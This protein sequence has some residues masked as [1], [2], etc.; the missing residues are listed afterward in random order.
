MSTPRN[1]LTDQEI[2]DILSLKSNHKAPEIA[3]RIGRG[4]SVVRRVLSAKLLNKPPT[5][6]PIFF[7]V[8]QYFLNNST[9]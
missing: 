1:K 6:N 2:A 8:D 9:I 5:P 4:E 7:Q 3:K